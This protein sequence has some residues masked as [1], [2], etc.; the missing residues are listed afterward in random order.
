[1]L[2]IVARE[3]MWAGRARSAVVVGLAMILALLFGTGCNQGSDEGQALEEQQQALEEQQ[4]KN[5][6]LQKELDA[7]EEEQEEAEKQ[8]QAAEQEEMQQKIDDLEKE[9][10]ENESESQQTGQPE[11]ESDSPDV[12]I[13][14][15]ADWTAPPSQAGEGVVVVSPDF[16]V[17]AVTTEE[18]QALD[19][20]IAYY[21]AVEVGDYYTTHS[22]L[23]VDDQSLY[24]LD[25]W[26]E[27][28]T[29][30]DSAA[31][32]FVVTGAYPDDLGNGYPAYAVTVAVYLPDGS[33]FR[34][35]KYFTKQGNGFWAHSLSQEEMVVFE[36]TL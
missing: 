1:M 35:T 5:D 16:D 27:A 4:Q 36:S 12:V 2:R 6:E 25:E 19:A 26:V 3:V 33:S 14:S 30:L 24:P 31:G 11:P 10:A 34:A 17:Q 7:Q 13:E 22:L 29:N 8:Q 23:S 15:N 21:Q 9:V 32:E 18:A 28:N 20:A